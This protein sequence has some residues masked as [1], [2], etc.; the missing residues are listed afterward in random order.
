MICADLQ[1]LRAP[2]A[3]DLYWINPPRDAWALYSPASFF[4]SN[5]DGSALVP[6][7]KSRAR[8]IDALTVTISDLAGFSCVSGLQKVLDDLAAVD[9]VPVP[10][11]PSVGDV[12]TGVVARVGYFLGFRRVD[13]V[14]VRDVPT[15]AGFIQVDI[16]A[17]NYSTPPSDGGDYGFRL[18]FSN[19]T[20]VVQGQAVRCNIEAGAYAPEAV[21]L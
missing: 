5:A 11:Y 2:F 21:I 1:N 4:F 9:V 7:I 19:H 20:E 3:D 13:G 6:A 15:W 16:A 10:R 18:C 8:L 14:L 12:C 17:N